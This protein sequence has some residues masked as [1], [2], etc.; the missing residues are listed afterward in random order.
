M[1]SLKGFDT[2][3]FQGGTMNK[4]RGFT[5]IEILVTVLILGVLAAVALPGFTKV[6]T[7]A[8]KD[9]VISYLRTIRTSMKM[10]YG[11]WKTYVPLSNPTDIKNILG[12]ETQ[13]A[14]YSIAVTA[15]TSTT[16]SA[17]ATRYSDSKTVA[18][19]QDGTWSGSNTPLPPS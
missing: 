14:G 17:T 12:A 18:I 19:D 4:K 1:T 3:L 2:E 9:Q 7:K 8:E 16:F 5:L 15:P 10:Y 11:K 6:K 13:T